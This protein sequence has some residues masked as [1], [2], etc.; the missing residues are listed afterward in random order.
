M[1]MFMSGP[2][3]KSW[4]KLEMRV[5]DDTRR[6][7][8]SLFYLA[9]AVRGSGAGADLHRYAMRFMRSHGVGLAQLQVSPSNATAM[10]SIFDSSPAQPSKGPAVRRRSAQPCFGNQGRAVVVPLRDRCRWPKG[11]QSVSVAER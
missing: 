3:E 10:R 9:E 4:A 1:G 6:G 7:H 2:M 5:L 8:V 11:A